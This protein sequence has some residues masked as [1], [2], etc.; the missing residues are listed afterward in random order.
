MG[1]VPF[2]SKELQNIHEQHDII[3][4]INELQKV[5]SHTGKVP[6]QHKIAPI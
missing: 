5:S 4:K 3:L 2:I 6:E 1:V